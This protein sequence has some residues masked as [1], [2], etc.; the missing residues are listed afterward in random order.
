MAI[1]AAGV[2][3]IAA[4]AGG[5]IADRDGIAA[6]AE[7]GGGAMVFGLHQASAFIADAEA[8]GTCVPAVGVG[9]VRVSGAACGIAV[10][11]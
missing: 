6:G 4:G 7:V 11:D 5:G 9:A 1:A 2:E 8:C 3:A 10:A